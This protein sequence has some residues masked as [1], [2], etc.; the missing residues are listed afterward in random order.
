[1]TRNYY[2]LYQVIQNNSQTKIYLFPQ[3]FNSLI[4]YILSQFFYK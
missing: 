4:L 1:M 2:H 3:I